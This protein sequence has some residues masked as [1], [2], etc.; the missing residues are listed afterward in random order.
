MNVK[1]ISSFFLYNVSWFM[2]HY[3]LEIKIANIRHNSIC[4]TFAEKLN[5]ANHNIASYIKTTNET[6][7]ERYTKRN[8]R[9]ISR[10]LM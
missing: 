3:E 6:Q 5:K 8:H 10:I 1:K 7:E 4:V 9:K 2:P